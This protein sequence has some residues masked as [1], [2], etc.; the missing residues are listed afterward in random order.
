V[1]PAEAMLDFKQF[2]VLTFDCYGTLID[3]ESGIFYALRPILS[4][5]RKD[6]EDAAVLELFGELEAAAEQGEYQ[7]YKSVL[8]SVVRGFGERLGFTP[9]SEEIQSLPASLPNW[10]PFPDTV[11]ALRALHSRFRLAVISNTDDDLF[12]ASAR[13]LQVPFDFVITAEQAR[14]YKPDLKIFRMALERIA[15]AHDRVLHVGQSIYHDVV[16]AKSLAVATVWVNRPS[17]RRGS[18]ATKPAVGTPD[19]QVSSLKELADLVDA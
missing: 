6:I 11:P 2:Q 3:W 8:Q 12:A 13:H 5:H 14:C 1:C 18:G 9:T 19:L 17:P 15:F 7:N 16:P 4:A 10:R